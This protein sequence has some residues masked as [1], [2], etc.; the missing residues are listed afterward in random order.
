MSFIYLPSSFHSKPVWL[1]LFC[2]KVNFCSTG[3]FQYNVDECGFSISK[4]T[5]SSTIVV[6][7]DPFYKSVQLTWFMS[8]TS[9]MITWSMEH[10][11]QNSNMRFYMCKN[12]LCV[13]FMA[14]NSFVLVLSW[15][16][17]VFDTLLA[18]NC[19]YLQQRVVLKVYMQELNLIKIFTVYKHDRMLL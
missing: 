19:I 17:N 6:H 18:A 1:S 9:Y 12:I 13:I 2:R 3:H 11:T 7:T 5:K 8:S 16:F 10:M 4:M 14:Q 15:I